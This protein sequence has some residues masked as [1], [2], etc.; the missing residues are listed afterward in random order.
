MGLGSLAGRGGRGERGSVL[1]LIPAGFLVLILLGALA[2]DSAAAYQDRNQLHD[3]LSAAANDAVAAG[4]NPRS[5]YA[6]GTLALD[7]ARVAD[8]VCRS[9][10]AQAP[11]SLHGLR[12]GIA[13]SATTLR[14][15][16]W[17]SVDGIFGR[18]VPGFGTRTV[19]ATAEASLAGDGVS[20]PSTQVP[21]GPPI[22]VSCR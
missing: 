9:V 14:V 6:G 5:F 4:L 22:A 8:V 18:A 13:W 17:A 10:A 21:T 19:Q 20:A 3:A 16:G 11:Q 7:P 15:V 1:A 12:L 2:V